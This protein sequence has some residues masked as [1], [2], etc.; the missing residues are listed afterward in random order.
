MRMNLISAPRGDDERNSQDLITTKR[1]IIMRNNANEEE[2][3]DAHKFNLIISARK[4]DR[5]YNKIERG[6]ES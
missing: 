3:E 1:R 2:R 4:T 6:R 5:T